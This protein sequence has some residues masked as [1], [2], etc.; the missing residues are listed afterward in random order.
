MRIKG[1]RAGMQG[2]GA[3]EHMTTPGQ[4]R[5]VHWLGHLDSSQAEA[6]MW[7]SPRRTAGGSPTWVRSLMQ[8]SLR[9]AIRVRQTDSTSDGVATLWQWRGTA[10][11][12]QRITAASLELPDPCRARHH[13]SA[14]EEVASLWLASSD[15][16]H[17]G[18]KTGR[19]EVL[20]VAGQRDCIDPRTPT[21][22]IGA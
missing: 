16:A 15:G 22:T 20:T 14:L 1:R 5:R 13:H 12:N 9:C 11:A 18:N 17:V 2:Q 7:K 10:C 4:R 6:G 21:H 8:P 3:A 19:D